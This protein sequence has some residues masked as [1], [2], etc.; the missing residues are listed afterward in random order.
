M[1]I[2]W[3]T[4]P[5]GGFSSYYQYDT[6]SRN[7]TRI[8][9]ELGRAAKPTDDGGT[10]ASFKDDRRVGFSD[11]RLSTSNPSAHWTVNEAGRLCFDGTELSG[12]PKSDSRVY[13]TSDPDSFVHVGN[14]ITD[15]PTLPPGIEPKHLALLANKAMITKTKIVLSARD[16]T[17]D[18]LVQSLRDQ[19]RDIV[20]ADDFDEISDDTILEVLKDQVR[21]IQDNAVD[22]SR[23]SVQQAL[24]AVEVSSRQITEMLTDGSLVP[25]DGITAAVE[26]LAGA[27]ARAKTQTGVAE[28]Q[29]ALTEVKTAQAAMESA[30]DEA[31]ADYRTSLEQQ[32]RVSGESMARAQQAAE[33][34][35]RVESKYE[36]LVEADSFDSYEREMIAPSEDPFA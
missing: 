12:I 27:V 2:A 18:A 6:V 19:V 9:L 24:D 33:T 22:P 10:F 7:F 16:A 21:T 35:Q 23:T 13:D 28:I 5:P 29:Q 1:I 34:W 36:D 11:V 3:Y 14:K 25:N 20:G 30:I 8:R 17:P 4:Q 26:G 15:T 32:L 31:S